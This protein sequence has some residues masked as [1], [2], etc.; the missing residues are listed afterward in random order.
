MNYDDF[1]IEEIIKENFNFTRELFW[2]NQGCVFP[3][4]NIFTVWIIIASRNIIYSNMK[5]NH[6]LGEIGWSPR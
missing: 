5:Q 4:K 2:E 1:L 3:S 6:G